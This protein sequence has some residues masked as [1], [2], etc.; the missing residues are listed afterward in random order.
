MHVL[1][2]CGIN[3]ANEVTPSFGFSWTYSC[4]YKSGGGNA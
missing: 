4:S 2:V 3:R 1:V